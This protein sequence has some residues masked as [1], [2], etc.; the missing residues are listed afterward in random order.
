MENIKIILV[1]FI[2]IIF[3]ININCAI[4]DNNAVVVMDESQLNESFIDKVN[5]SGGVRAGLMLNGSK[6]SVDFDQLYIYTGDG[7]EPLANSIL[8]VSMISNDGRYTSNWEYPLNQQKRSTITFSLKSRH[9]EQLAAYASSELVVLAAVAQ[10]SC[11]SKNL[12]YVPAS[13]GF[14]QNG[15]YVL[16]V[17]SGGADAAIS[18][19]GRKERIP[20][21]SILNGKTIAYDKK[22]EV[23]KSLIMQTKRMYLQRTN[24][25]NKLP[26]IKITLK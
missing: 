8:C 25:N 1:T 2:Q 18:I 9:K 10:E 6:Q 13:W 14:V 20:C 17:N 3:Y 4:A 21:D 12:E 24:F 5:V 7:N 11:E 23:D 26:D 15:N 22:C 19:P 16:F